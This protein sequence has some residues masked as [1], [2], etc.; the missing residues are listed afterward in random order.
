[1]SFRAV[2]LKSNTNFL[3]TNT[4]IILVPVGTLPGDG[5]IAFLG[6]RSANLPT[7]PGWTLINSVQASG[8]GP[9][10]A[11]FARIAENPVPASYT[12]TW[13]GNEVG[14]IGGISAWT[15]G[16]LGVTHADPAFVLNVAVPPDNMS[17]TLPAHAVAASRSE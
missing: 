17:L 10:L 4:C 14:I 2:S 16:L 15:Q 7:A 1:M 13:A 5:L 9:S 12:F 8:V 11:V 6:N 3:N